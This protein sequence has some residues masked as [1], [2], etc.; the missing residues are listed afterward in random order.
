M[1]RVAGWVALGAGGLAVVIAVVVFAYYWFVVG[2]QG[3]YV[4]ATGEDLPPAALA[5]VLFWFGIIAIP[6][7]GVVSIVSLV[8]W[9]TGLGKRALPTT[10]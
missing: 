10:T 8:Y 1:R 2:E 9:I 5:E 3:L 7:L 6:A 4:D